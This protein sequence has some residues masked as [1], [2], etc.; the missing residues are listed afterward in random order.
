MEG[1]D[2]G[3]D[4]LES[5]AGAEGGGAAG[6]PDRTPDASPVPSPDASP[7]SG[8][9]L[10]RIFRSRSRRTADTIHTLVGM[11]FEQQQ[12]EAAVRHVGP[13]TS[14][15][16]DFILGGGEV[17]ENLPA[18]GADDEEGG[19]GR[20]GGAAVQAV[21]GADAVEALMR[22][23]DQPDPSGRLRN[24]FET[25]QQDAG[26]AGE[27]QWGQ[28]LQVLLSRVGGPAERADGVTEEAVAAALPETLATAEL[29]HAAGSDGECA[30]PLCMEP[31]VPG[32][33]VAQLPCGH[34]FHRSLALPSAEELPRD[35]TVNGHEC[36]LVKFDQLSYSAW[37]CDV[38]LRNQG[39]SGTFFHDGPIGTANDN[40]FDVC[41]RCAQKHSALCTPAEACGGID[42]WL[43]TT[44]NC[45][46]CRAPALAKSDEDGAAAEGAAA[47][48]AEAAEVA[49]VAAQPEGEAGVAVPPASDRDS[50]DAADRPPGTP[51]AEQLLVDGHDPMASMREGEGE[52]DM[53]PY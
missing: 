34:V 37:I 44:P 7:R 28:L 41:V 22:A 25:L 9:R 32:E 50:A 47:E 4:G 3:V 17:A 30:C 26:G 18:E 10:P 46:V 36:T 8:S 16:V 51:D 45:P 29:V 49:L 19:G 39:K 12:A 14:R 27:V 31:V 52:L 23:L 13:D 42:S 21:V 15:A 20:A 43:M 5:L 48:G 2:G 11:G 1:L 53:S 33:R 38:C 6:S 24:L 40:G 35:V